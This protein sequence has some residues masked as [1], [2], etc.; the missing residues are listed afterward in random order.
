MASGS[1]TSS[2]SVAPVAETRSSRSGSAPSRRSGFPSE[3]SQKPPPG[4]VAIPPTSRFCAGRPSRVTTMAAVIR[5]GIRVA[6]TVR[7]LASA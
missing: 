6:S 5:A 2:S 4:R 7:I 1:R 3:T